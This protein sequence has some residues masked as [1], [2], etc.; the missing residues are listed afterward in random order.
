MLLNEW[1]SRCAARLTELGAMT[2]NF[3]RCA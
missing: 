3:K 1:G 2:L